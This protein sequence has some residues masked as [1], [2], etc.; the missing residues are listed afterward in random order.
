MQGRYLHGATQ[1]QNKYRTSVPQVGFELMIPVLERAK[2]FHAMHR[3]A[4]V[5][6]ISVYLWVY[7]PLLGLGHFFSFLIFY[8]VG[9]TPWTG[10]Q[11]VVRPLPPQNKRIQIS[12]PRMGSHGPSVRAGEPGSCLRPCDHY[13]PLIC[14]FFYSIIN[15]IC[16]LIYHWSALTFCGFW[17]MTEYSPWKSSELFFF[18]TGL[19]SFNIGYNVVQGCPTSNRSDAALYSTWLRA[20]W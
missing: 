7:S 17:V 9:R 19:F 20:A 1:T 3:A 10:D 11:L 12:M 14:V 6:A 8:T 13:D 5:N 2:T 18:K 16:H 4:T 15:L